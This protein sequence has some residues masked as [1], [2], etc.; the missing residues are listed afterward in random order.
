MGK[1]KSS[2]SYRLRQY[3]SEF[4]DVLTSDRKVISFRHVENLLSRSHGTQHLS[5]SKNIS[6]V[7]GQKF[8]QVGSL[9]LASLLL[10]FL[11][12]D[13]PNLPCLQQICANHLCPLILLNK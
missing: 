8:G 3:V 1:V 2:D 7:V 4:K 5:R 11:V 9:L 10:Q 6:A 12:Q 13:L